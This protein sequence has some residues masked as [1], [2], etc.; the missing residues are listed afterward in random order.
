M[1]HI[2]KTGFTL[3]LVLGA[4][5]LYAQSV[6]V[7]GTVYDENNLPLPGTSIII[8][9]TPRGTTTGTNGQFSLQAEKGQTLVFSF[10]GYTDKIMPV[11]TNM[12]NL[13]VRMET[14]ANAIEEVVVSVGYGQMARKDISGA[15]AT[16][17]ASDLEKGV[18]SAN[19]SDALAGRM[20]GVQVTSSEGGP[21]AGVDITIRGG[22]SLT[23]SNAPLWV[24]DGFPIE[25]PNTFSID[26]KDIEQMQVLKDASATAIYGARG[27]NGVII[28]ETKKGTDDGKVNVEYNGKFSISTLPSER[29]MKMLQGLDYLYMAQSVA[30]NY[31]S[32][33]FAT[34]ADR[35][36]VNDL[37]KRD[38]PGGPY[39][40]DAAGNRIELT[41]AKA[42]DWEKLS[43]EDYANLPWTMHDWQDEAFKNAITHT[44]RVA[45]N[46]GNKTTKYNVSTDV[47]LQDGLLLNTGIDKYNFRASLDQQLSKKFRFVG[48]VNYNAT[49]RHGLQSSE[50][51][52]NSIIRDILQYQPVNPMKYGDLGVEGVPADVDTD[53][54]NLTYHPIRNLNNAYR[55]IYIDQ[56]TI[57]GTLHYQ[58]AK[59]LKLMIRGGYTHYTT[60]QDSYNNADSR[61]GHPILQ[62]N[63]INAYKSQTVRDTWFNE[64][65]LTYAKTWGR[66]R[67]DVMGGYTMEGYLNKSVA[68]TYIKFPTDIL[69]MDNLSQGTAQPAV[70]SVEEYF[71]MSF[72]GRVNYVYNDKYIFTASFRADGSSKFL[73]DNKFGYF[74]SG[75]F[76]WRMSQE[77]FLRD[78]HWLSNLK[79]RASWG[80]TGNNRIGGSSAYSALYN[81][82][83]TGYL[84]NGSLVYGYQPSRVENRELKWETTRQ[85]DIGIDFAVFNNR[86]NLTVDWY[87]K[88]TKDLLLYSDLATSSGYQSAYL[89]IGSVQNQGWEFALNTTNIDHKNFRWYTSFNISFNRNKVLGLNSGQEYM[90]SKPNWYQNYDENQYIARVGQPASMIYGYI[91]DGVYQ[92]EDFYYVDGQYVTKPGVPGQIGSLTNLKPGHTKYRD[93]NGDGKID[94]NDMTVIGNPNPKHYGGFTNSFELYNFDLSVFF[95]WVAGNDILNANETLLTSFDSSRNNYLTKTTQFWS[96]TN[97]TNEMPAIPSAES[98]IERWVTSRSVEDGSYLRLQNITLGYNLNAK[99]VPFLRKI[100]L[101]SLRVYFA[102]DNLFVWTDYTGYDPEVN[103]NSSA[104]MRGLDYCSYPRSRTFTFGLDLKF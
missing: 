92:N 57:N 4:V 84:F 19:F 59:P 64:Y 30:N 53:T 17:K 65:T 12:T 11:E 81:S 21:G 25:N 68:N 97:P 15:V 5:T 1:K 83:N 54:G 88:K 91:Y 76:A 37:Y 16:V 51:N 36:L 96:P 55:E 42:E 18:V 98:Q 31:S 87:H 67:F 32:T 28:I 94:A 3:L 62:T 100:G 49:R 2:L 10:I 40:L 71:T 69:G 34:F 29:K 22:N 23:G 14:S 35:Y 75:A 6:P 13:S 33:G 93:I 103:T 8:Q 66:H 79:L 56:L 39:S 9:G 74:P 61:Y 70:T 26:S 85:A 63:G 80:L 20:A 78:V 82:A 73:G 58:I 38:S 52:R 77:N 72:L 50:G 89:N 45:I 102:A 41:Y 24:I 104:L 101:T 46:G 86:I 7:T 99:K 44:H 90:L 95:T 60:I 48:L 27:A 47:F 43:I